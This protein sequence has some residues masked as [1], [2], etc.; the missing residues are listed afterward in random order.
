MSK[1]ASYAIKVKAAG[2]SRWGGNV[3]PLESLDMELTE[4]C[5]NNCIHCYINLPADDLHAKQKE[6]SKEEVQEI[7]RVAVSLGCLTIKFTGG[8]P[9]LREDFEE[10]YI[11]ARKLGLRVTLLTNATLITPALA[12]VFVRTP[13]LNPIEVTLYGMK[14]SSYESVSSVSGSFAAAWQ[15]VQVLLEKKVPF[16]VKGALLPPNRQE[17]EEFESWAATIPWTD[18]IPSYSLFFDLRA[19][20]DSEQKNQLIR[21]LRLSPEDVVSFFFRRQEKYLTEMRAFCSKFTRP[22]GKSIFACGAGLR[23]GCVD[24]H[25]KLQLCMLLRHPATVYDLKR[26]TLKDAL[27]NFFP[28]IR[29]S[30][31]TNLDYLNRCARCFLKGLCEQC[32]ARSWME[33]GTLDTPVEYHCTI[34]HARARA[35]GLLGESELAWEI[36]RWEG[37]LRNF[38]EGKP[39]SQKRNSAEARSCTRS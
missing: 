21:D 29:K 10:L 27:D 9:L 14:K 16:I 19:R 23:S 7:L 15:G 33:H 34:A 2:I 26:G 1:R 8:E 35:L 31:A 30:S 36:E 20:Q 28:K 17:I 4:R 38:A 24:A 5:N 3:P 39:I 6:L 18:T 22:S 11:F 25:G 13:P 12:K 32:P 37:R